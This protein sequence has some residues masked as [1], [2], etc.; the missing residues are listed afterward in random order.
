MNFDDL[1]TEFLRECGQGRMPGDAL[2][3]RLAE[4]CGPEQIESLLTLL[5]NL[6]DVP[7]DATF[8]DIP[9]GDDVRRAA[10]GT[11]FRAIGERA[12]APLLAALARPNPWTRVSAAV[13][14]SQLRVGRAFEPIADLLADEPN[15]LRQMTLIAALGELRDPRAVPLLMPYLERTAGDLESPF[16]QVSAVALGWLGATAVIPQ[17]DEIIRTSG[18]EFARLHAVR[19][20]RGMKSKAAMDV[21]ASHAVNDADLATR[22]EAAE[23]L[24]EWRRSP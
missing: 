24:A 20:L 22:N 11:L 18:D 12:T 7:P 4:Q 5:D 1:L 15:E 19:G 16:G 13:A 14:L 10:F 6:D 8:D 21:I 17:L 9:G 23:A 3:A 2:V